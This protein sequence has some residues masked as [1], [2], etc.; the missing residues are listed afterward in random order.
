[1]VHICHHI[2]DAK[3]QM[4]DTGAASVICN[5]TC[6]MN[7]RHGIKAATRELRNATRP[8]LRQRAPGSVRAVRAVRNTQVF[9]TEPWFVADVLVAFQPIYESNTSIMGYC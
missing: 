3:S 6:R 8:I 4:H 5:V 9:L 2:L 7:D 1:M